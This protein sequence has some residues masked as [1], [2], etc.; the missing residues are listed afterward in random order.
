[1]DLAG[2]GWHRFYMWSDQRIPV[3]KPWYASLLCITVQKLLLLTLLSTEGGM[4]L[5]GANLAATAAAMTR[6]R[7]SSADFVRRFAW[8]KVLLKLFS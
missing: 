3:G 5:Y 7:D 2:K 8:M 1:M 4:I 6:R